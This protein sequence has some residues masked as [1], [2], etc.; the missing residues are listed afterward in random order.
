LS[1]PR[2]S[3]QAALLDAH[4]LGG[5]PA[6]AVVVERLLAQ[7][8]PSDEARPFYEGLRILGARTPELALIALRLTL[9]GRRPDDGT[10][11]RARELIALARAGGAGAPAAKEAYAELLR[12]S[13]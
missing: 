7:P 9:A 3:S 11:S 13:S 1:S 5:E 2:G 4:L 12:E 6:R 8:P 10:V